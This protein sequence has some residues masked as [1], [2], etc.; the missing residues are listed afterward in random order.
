MSLLRALLAAVPLLASQALGAQSGPLNITVAD[1]DLKDILRAAATGTGTSL[2]FEPGL[3]TRVQG[4]DLKATSLQELLD[5]VLPRYGLAAT[6]DGRF[7]YVHRTEGGMRF[8]HLDQLAMSRSATK[9]FT[10]NASGQSTANGGGA[11]GAGAGSAFTSSV[12]LANASDPWAEVEAGLMLL[13]FGKTMERQPAPAQ[14]PAMPAAGSQAPVSRGW[15]AGGKTLLI[16]P[17]SGIVAVDA[18]PQSQKRVEAY[19]DETRRR[20]RRQ[21][22]LE[23]RIVEVALGQGSEMGVD[24]NGLLSRAGNPGQSFFHSGSPVDPVLADPALGTLQIVASSQRVQATLAA[25][26]YNNRINVLSAPRLATLNNQKAVLR[27]VRERPFV[28]PASQISPGTAGGAAVA[29][30]QITPFIV[31]EGIVLDIQPQI[32]DD[33]VISLAVNPSITEVTSQT[34]FT[35]GSPLAG[36]SPINA[37]LPTVERRDL[38]TVV[39]IRSGQTLV[40]AGLIRKRALSENQ[41][42]PWVRK[43]PLLGALFSRDQRTEQRTELAIFI[44]PTLMDTDAQMES[45]RRDTEK[46]MGASGIDVDPPPP[47]P[48]PGMKT[49]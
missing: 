33:G 45:L 43:I 38:D 32:G 9:A 14:A 10:V 16:Q 48:R 36:G 19:L 12:Q 11:T 7:I 22:L 41:G 46:R 49:P 34:N 1:A 8:Y 35:E 27:V 6:R 20:N 28:L 5:K 15:S 39:R 40:L 26:A 2:I 30:Q 4:L 29:V 17:G 25:L 3:D 37:T 44:T 13:V 42:V 23:A 24:W 21:V 18:D 31:P 47:P